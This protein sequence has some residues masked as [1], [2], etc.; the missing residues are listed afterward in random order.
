MKQVDFHRVFDCR[1]RTAGDRPGIL[2]NKCLQLFAR[3]RTSSPKGI[4][5]AKYTKKVTFIRKACIRLRFLPSQ[6]GSRSLSF[7]H[8]HIS[9]LSQL[10]E[11]RIVSSL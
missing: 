7:C 1:A 5:S 8:I 6:T 11:G 9:A 4:R 10:V 3:S 2:I